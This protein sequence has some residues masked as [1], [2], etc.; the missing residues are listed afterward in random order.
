MVCFITADTLYE[1]ASQ[2]C[3][4]IVYGANRNA[5]ILA[6]IFNGRIG[7]L[8]NCEKSPLCRFRYFSV[9]FTVQFTVQFF[10]NIFSGL[11]FNLK[12][13]RNGYAQKEIEELKWFA[14]QL[15]EN[16]FEWLELNIRILGEKFLN[17]FLCNFFY[18]SLTIKKLIEINTGFHTR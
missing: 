7:V 17:H 18:L 5:K 15:Y 9:Q 1:L 10:R 16:G 12:G 4:M 3:N 6:Q 11:V 8:G 13:E 2:Q 14:K